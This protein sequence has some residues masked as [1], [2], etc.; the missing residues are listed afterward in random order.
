MGALS[1]FFLSPIYK[2]ISI[3]F[4][5]VLPEALRFVILST[6]ILCSYIKNETSR[7][8]Y[9]SQINKKSSKFIF[10]KKLRPSSFEVI[11]MECS[12]CLCEFKEGDEARELL[13]KHV[14]HKNCLEKWL[15]G[16]HGTC[17]LCRRLV[18]PETIATEHGRSQDGHQLLQNSMEEELALIL[19]STM[20]G[21]S[22]HS[23]F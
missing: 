8:D 14:F 5:E 22:C 11:T 16:S 13:C 4:S 12:I 7:H 23:G 3:Y 18:V 1:K 19:L 6:F 17:P 15:R 21:W 10:R 20:S 2:V 9:M